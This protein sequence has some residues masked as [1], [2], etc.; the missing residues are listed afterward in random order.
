MAIS[1]TPVSSDEFE[2]SWARDFSVYPPL[3]YVLR[4]N[5]AGNWTR[6]HS[7]SKSKRYPE[8]DLQRQSVLSRANTLAKECFGSRST[9]WLV[10]EKYGE[11]D[12]ETNTLIEEE[13]MVH[14]LSWVDESE[15]LADQRQREFWAAK[16]AWKPTSLDRYFA[17]VLEDEYR[18]VLYDP[19]T[20]T[21]LAPYDGG[22][23]I[24]SL[25]NEF[26]VSIEEKYQNWM[27]ERLDKM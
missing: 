8:T 9:L 1:K 22:F 5:L 14:V 23:D 7:L 19:A 18:L 17:G 21:L 13:R 27:S 25:R 3:G 26:L 20:S 24:F 2:S 16:V 6:F 4:Q 10:T 15:E 11:F 12:L